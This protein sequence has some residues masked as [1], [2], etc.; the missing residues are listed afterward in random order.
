ML[1]P[2]SP[3]RVCADYI[4]AERIRLELADP[5]VPPTAGYAFDLLMSLDPADTQ[6]VLPLKLV[7]MGP[8]AESRYEHTFR[9]LIP[10][11]IPIVAREPG[12]YIVSIRELF[13][14]RFAGR[15]HIEVR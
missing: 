4:R 11:R 6:L 13:H 10:R 1:L 15:L 9:R 3:T 5:S 2:S 7:V 12:R 14:N 8:S